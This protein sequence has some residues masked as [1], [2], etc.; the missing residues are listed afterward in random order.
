VAGVPGRAFF[1]EDKGRDLLRVCFAKRP[2]VL[3]DA[4]A[5]LGRPG[6]RERLE[7]P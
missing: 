1:T 7:H 5:R 3:E 4:C 2:H 6:L